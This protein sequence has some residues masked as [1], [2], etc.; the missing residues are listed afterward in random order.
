MP[1]SPADAPEVIR[2]YFDS[3]NTEDFE[4]LAGIWADDVELKAVGARPR[5]GRDDVMDFYGGI[6]EPWA[7]HD[8]HPTRVVADGDV[9]VV[10]I[11]FTGTTHDGKEI[12][13]PA[14]DIFDLEDGKIRK[15]SIYYDLT[16]VRKQMS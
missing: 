11:V 8:D 2:T 6:F 4:R 12:S 1:G 16:W 10:E 14:V 5:T 15:V 7:A 13:F 9:V 3:I